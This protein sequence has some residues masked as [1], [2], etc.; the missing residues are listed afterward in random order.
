MPRFQKKVSCGYL[1]TCNKAVITVVF[2][3]LVIFGL[4]DLFFLQHI[5][6]CFLGLMNYKPGVWHP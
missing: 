2:E 4:W 6:C 5:C 1:K 3:A